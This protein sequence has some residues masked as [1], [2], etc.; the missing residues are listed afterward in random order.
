MTPERRLAVFLSTTLAAG[1][2]TGP[3]DDVACT[4]VPLGDDCP[5]PEVAAELLIGTRTCESPVREVTNIGAFV[6]SSDVIY[7]GYGGSNPYEPGDTGFSEPMTE[8]C[9][10]ASYK[11]HEGEDCVIGRAL[12]D[13]GA[14]RTATVTQTGQPSPA[15]PEIEALSADQRACLADR[16]ETDALYEHASIFAFERLAD[17]LDALGAPEDLVRRARR[18]A[19]DEAHHAEDAFAIASALRG[20]RVVAGPMPPVAPRRADLVTVA[21]ESLRDGY[22]GETVAVARAAAQLR[23]ATDPAVR[24]ALIR[25]IRDESEHAALGLDVARWAVG[26]DVGARA[27]LASAFANAALPSAGDGEGP[28]FGAPH[29]DRV[30]AVFR[31]AWSSVVAPTVHELLAA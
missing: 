25:V 21:V 2:G 8:C 29:P 26:N 19:A 5:S 15:G 28:A 23:D 14:P 3:L 18:A 13:G 1:C 10:E 16:W 24:A 17:E 20:S 27:A 12:R 11:E 22:I 6:S 30:A 9:Y 31:A 4:A 7:T